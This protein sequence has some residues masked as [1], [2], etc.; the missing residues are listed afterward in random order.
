[1]SASTY[2][3]TSLALNRLRL[4]Q[5]SSEVALRSSYSGD[6]QSLEA[7]LKRTRSESEQQQE[8]LF[9]QLGTHREAWQLW[10]RLYDH[11]DK[12]AAYLANNPQARSE[13]DDIKQQINALTR[14]QAELMAGR[15]KR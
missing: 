6:P 3:A 10:P 12:I 1:M 4:K 9:A 2:V 7:A 14:Q 13:L 15:L 5:L 11:D 8:A